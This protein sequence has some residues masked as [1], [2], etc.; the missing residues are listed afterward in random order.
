MNSFNHQKNLQDFHIGLIPD[1]RLK[2]PAYDGIGVYSHSL[3]SAL[4]T[5][6]SEFSYSVFINEQ[7]QSFLPEFGDNFKVIMGKPCSANRTYDV[8]WYFFV[9]PLLARKYQIDLLHIFSGNRRL[10]LFPFNRTVVSIH[11]I[12]YYKRQGYGVPRHLLFRYVLAPL[13]KLHPH[14][15]AVSKSTCHELETT[16]QI[17]PEKIRLVENAYDDR[18]FRV[19]NNAEIKKEMRKKYSLEKDFMLYVSVLDY[20]RKNHVTLIRA[21]SHLKKIVSQVPDLVLVGE[22]FWQPEVIYNEIYK[23]GLQEHVKILGFIP[24]DDLV[25]LYNAAK[26]FVHPSNWEGFGLPILEAMACGLPV[27]CSDIPTFREIAGDAPVYFDQKDPL[28]IT[29]S[30]KMLCEN[31]RLYAA[32]QLKG[33]ERAKR[34]TWQRTAKRMVKVYLDVLTRVG[35]HSSGLT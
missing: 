29:G 27:V 13:L 24:Y 33:L 21:Y 8:A 6:T 5:I 20:P 35:G 25:I 32:S 15:H 10:S 1:F 18:H 22:E 30:I 9:L 7:D 14:I 28:S 12:Y 11:D 34:F 31:S 17:S 16:F 23:N 19:I 2:P 3:I 4:N 26:L